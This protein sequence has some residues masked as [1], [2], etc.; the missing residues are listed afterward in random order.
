MLHVHESYELM[1]FLTF[2]SY[3]KYVFKLYCSWIAWSESEFNSW[4]SSYRTILQ[5]DPPSS[6][7]EGLSWPTA[8]KI[9]KSNSF[10]CLHKEGLNN[11]LQVK[12]LTSYLFNYLQVKGSNLGHSYSCM[13][14][15]L[16]YSCMNMLE[17][18]MHML[19]ILFSNILHE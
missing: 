3:F 15:M 1:H 7:L 9:E 13:V 4:P 17:K 14:H 19:H 8:S 18:L 10:I 2:L 11:C 6:K 5:G 16:M 12:G